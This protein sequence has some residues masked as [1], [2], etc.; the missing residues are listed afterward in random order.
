M[1]N[2]TQ[3]MIIYYMALVLK[4]GPFADNVYL[5]PSTTMHELNLRAVDYIRMEE[6]KTLRTI[7]CTNFQPTDRKTDKPPTRTDSRP[8]EPRPPDIRDMSP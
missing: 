5:R 3:E 1:K 7:F 8:K 4:L 6:M 2:L